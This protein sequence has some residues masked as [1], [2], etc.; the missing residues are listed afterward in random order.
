MLGVL[1]LLT[2]HFQF[3]LSESYP[4]FSVVIILW[5]DEGKGWALKL[6]FIFKKKL[7]N[8]VRSRSRH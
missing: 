3:L 7:N 2:G 8:R 6:S 1:T 5:R 4:E